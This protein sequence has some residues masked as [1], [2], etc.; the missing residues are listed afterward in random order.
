MKLD[1]RGELR[2]GSTW[3]D[4]TGNI[5]K[6][7][8]LNH[9]RGRQDQS[10]QMDPSTCRPLINNTNGQFSPDNP[11]S[12]YYEQFGRNS[13]FRVSVRAGSPA[14]DVPG[15]SS[16]VA[17]TPD[18]A[19]LD[20]V[21][22]LDVRVDATLSN[23]TDYA[24]GSVSTTQL[25][26][27]FGFAA[28]TKSW[29]F[30]TR[31]GALYFEWSADGTATLSASS[32]VPLPITASG[33]MALRVTLDVDNGSSGRTITF[34]TAPSGT[35]GPWT[36]LGD[37]VVQAGVT[38]I[39]NSATAL[40]VGRAT[41]VAFTQPIGRF[42]RAE[43]RSG[44]GGSVV[45]SPDF[46]VPAVGAGSFVDS[47]GLTWTVTAPAAISDRR[48][49][50]SH[51]LAEYPTEW[52]ASGKH[53]WVDATTA[54]VLRRLRRGGHALDSTLRRR[55]PSFA[56][57]AYWPMEEGTNAT[58]ASSPIAGVRPLKLTQ[59]TWAS[60]DSLPSSNP[61]PVLASNGTDLSRL[62]GSIPAPPA[63]LTS[64]SVHFIY[65]L[66]SGPATERT[67]MRILSTGT[68]S[69][70]YILQSATTSTIFGRDADGAT[71]FTQ[72]ISTGS[73]LFGQWM[74]VVFEA[75]QDGGNVDWS[76]TWVDIGGDA[77]FFSS[78]FAGTV[79]RPIGV[80][81]PPDGYSA[82]LDGMA[83]GHISAW[84]SNITLAYDGAIDAW[85]G[86]TAGARMQR[87][88]DEENVPLIVCGTVA[89]QTLVGPQL[90]EGVLSLLQDAADADGGI[91]YEDREQP[92][93]RYRPRDSM[94]NQVPALVL[95]YAGKGLA[96][97]LKAS[98]D[99]DATIN[100]VTVSR[101]GGSSARVVLEE[102][103]L[104]I[105]APP[106]G[107]GTGYD[108]S[109]PLNLASDD[110]AE[111]IAY[112]RLHLGTYEGRRYPQ[113][114]VMVHKANGT[115]GLVDQIL[116]VDVGDKLVIQNPPPWLPPDDVELIVQGYTEEFDEFRWDITFNCTPARPWTVGVVDDDVLGKIDTDGSQMAAAITSSAT[117]VHVLTTEGIPW[118]TDGAE[119]PFDLRAGGE[120]MT[121]TAVTS[122][123]RDTFTRTV[124]N[125]WGTPDTGAAWTNV[126]GGAASDYA[127]N[128]SV[129]LHTLSTVDTTRRSGIT[130]VHADFDLYCDVTTSALATGDS[131]YGAVCARMLDA[132]NLYMT[133][134]EF[135]TSNTVV[136]TVR[137]MVAGV[138][139]QLGSSFTVPVTH[140]AG[141]FIRLRFQ[142]QGTTLRARAWLA[143]GREP[144]V[145]HI[146][147]T[148]SAITAAN[149]VGT[150]SVRTASNT[151]AASVAVQYDTYEVINPQTFTVTRGLVKAHAA[152]TDLR[153][154]NPLIVAL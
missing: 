96:T 136:V 22:D 23:W 151:N 90:P 127:T 37:P 59:A 40:R 61:L 114:S 144:A 20:I 132:N 146:E 68:V 30:G 94:Y 78:T 150:R 81:S 42:H 70:W 121:A 52:D 125:G 48:T 83:I 86:E 7:Q 25:L 97:P 26:G 49:R 153:L 129:A 120:V 109:F 11:L 74:R 58:Q 111:P 1:L 5:L 77:G 71:V 122:W 142:G 39:F 87:L 31:S 13:P 107:V 89:E 128:G 46:S 108:T 138:Q 14:L 145:W 72:G 79:G 66:D 91:L 88:A 84:P 16:A 149:Q 135:T 12:P 141:T 29:V 85:T 51:E 117:V 80:A 100:D 4:V 55:L 50:L 57:L 21:G 47:A 15:L 124:A 18:T 92:R 34:Y 62:H 105:Q 28:G 103:A 45:A 35:S 131:L 82:D 54:G 119:V 148:D 17:S 110:Q 98:G 43:V 38:S 140:V 116:A 10:S 147:T 44:I 137:K 76:I 9:S 130:A 115:P 93:L 69:E 53:V 73:G 19:A 102:G 101:V 133:R 8:L 139:T 27:K 32:T 99:D 65:R 63:T 118:T 126:G 56:P 104:S 95:D 60:A 134:I 64:W 67:F 41:D 113:V 75:V 112:W 123:L 36:Q 152:G 6:R 3:V 154:A 2:I 24:A 33:R 106:L 143:S